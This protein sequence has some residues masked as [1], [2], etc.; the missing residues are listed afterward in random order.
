MKRVLIFLGITLVVF[1]VVFGIVFGLGWEAFDTI[2]KN[3]TGLAEGSEW[4][5]KTYSLQGLTEYIGA[6]PQ[7]VSVVSYNVNAPDSGIFYN[8]DTPRTMGALQNILL[9]I[10]YERQV[11]EGILDPGKQVQISEL[12]P[13]ILPKMNERAHRAAL[14]DLSLSKGDN[15]SI[16]NLVAAVIKY[17]DLVMADWLFYFLES[18]ADSGVSTWDNLLRELPL[19]L[20][21]RPEPF[22]GI[23]ISLQKGWDGSIPETLTS[24][25][26]SHADSYIQDESFRNEIYGQFEQDYIG[27]NFQQERDAL[28]YFPK[29]IPKEFVDVIARIQRGELISA[30]ASQRIKDKLRWPKDSTPIKRSFTDYGAIYD[31]RMGMLSGIDFGTSI[32]DD[33]TSV[34]AVFFDSLQIAFWLHM[35]AN[36]MQEDYQQRLI[37]DPALY[38]ATQKA[39]LETTDDE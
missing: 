33:H 11:E 18:N 30:E 15:I 13:F 4:V 28:V 21:N 31:T 17:N 26:R 1:G 10:E 29:V 24:V 22:I 39:I 6:N 32:Y 14:A 8:A 20:K 35:S 3:R 16:D 12:E 19:S 36:H 7:H 38:D 37:W 34:Q 2:N 25:P 9:L 27:L 5:E 23:Y